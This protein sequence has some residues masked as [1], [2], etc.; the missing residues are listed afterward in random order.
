MELYNGYKK[1]IPMQMLNITALSVDW[2][3][4]YGEPKNVWKALKA[5]MLY[6][7]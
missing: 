1:N 5:E 7:R 4:V 6:N 2:Y 3:Y